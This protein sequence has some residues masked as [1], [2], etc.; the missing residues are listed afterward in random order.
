MTF[1]ARYMYI[2]LQPIVKQSFYKYASDE[3]VLVNK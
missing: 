2:F 1:E 3:K